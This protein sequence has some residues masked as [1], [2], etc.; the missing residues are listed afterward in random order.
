LL[1]SVSGCA[2]HPAAAEPELDPRRSRTLDPRPIPWAMLV[3]T[4]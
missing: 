3:R 2:E 4:R 1:M